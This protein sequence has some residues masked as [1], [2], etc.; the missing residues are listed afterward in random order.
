LLN[1]LVALGLLTKQDGRFRNTP[2]SSRYFVA[3]SP[4]N[5][6]EALL[7]TVNLWH[8]W[9]FL[10]Y[11]VQTRDAVLRDP[12]RDEDETR[13]FIAAMDR[14]ARER[15]PLVVR[16]IGAEGVRRML[17]VG[18]GSGA[19]SIAFAKASPKLAA[20]VVDLAD[21][22]PIARANIKK[23][24]LTRRIKVRVGDLLRGPLGDGYDLVLVSA[25]CH[26]LS[27]DQ[28]LDLLQRCRRALCPGGRVAIQDFLLN[29]D[30]AG[31]KTA[32]LFSLNMLV[33]TE[34][35]ASY[36]EDE[37]AAWLRTAGFQ[38]VQRVSLPG[39]T[40]L[41]VARRS[42]RRSAARTRRSSIPK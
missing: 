30:K 8:R 25:I 4:D 39:P 3:G 15:A 20:E 2:T 35:G 36:S 21:V 27:P 34:A 6:R 19:Y 31:P 18:G 16:A 38:D 26:M 32:A 5:A 11:C 37:Y 1:A 13:A 7:H 23:A 22:V 40:G 24:G 10:T 28:N 42:R 29:P 33:G 17:D 14:N 9:A 41:M 12:F